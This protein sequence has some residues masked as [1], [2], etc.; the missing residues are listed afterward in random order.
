MKAFIFSQG[1]GKSHV[2]DNYSTA[3]NAVVDS[4][5]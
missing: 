1:A 2:S 4:V 3:V 5:K